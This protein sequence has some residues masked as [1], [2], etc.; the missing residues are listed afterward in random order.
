MGYW[1]KMRVC[2]AVSDLDKIRLPGLLAWT[3]LWH[4]MASRATRFEAGPIRLHRYGQVLQQAGSHRVTG[5][6][7]PGNIFRR[8]EIGDAPRMPVLL[9]SGVKFFDGVLSGCVTDGVDGGLLSLFIGRSRRRQSGGFFPRG[10]VLRS[11][12][13]YEPY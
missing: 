7:S 1:L 10:P 4:L 5:D 8:P 6:F 9:L 3:E 11:G 12:C 13:R 2:F